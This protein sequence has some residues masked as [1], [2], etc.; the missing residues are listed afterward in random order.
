VRLPAGALPPGE[1]GFAADPAD[2]SL[3]MTRTTDPTRDLH[4]LTG[5]AMANGMTLEELS[6]ARPSLEDTYLALTGHAHTDAVEPAEAPMRGR[7]R[8]R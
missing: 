4:A 3:M 7:R 6:V 1:L 8:R 5:W 2:R